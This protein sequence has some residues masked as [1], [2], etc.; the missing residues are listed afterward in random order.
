MQG[1]RDAATQRVKRAASPA[2]GNDERGREGATH[3]ADVAKSANA[4]VTMQ[5]LGEGHISSVADVRWRAGMREAVRTSVEAQAMTGQEYAQ[6]ALAERR[7][8]LRALFEMGLFD[9]ETRAMLEEVFTRF[10][11]EDADAASDEEER[12]DAQQLYREFQETF[13]QFHDS[14]KRI[15]RLVEEA[16]SEEPW[17]TIEDNDREAPAEAAGSAAAPSEDT[18]AERA[19]ETQ[20]EL[21]ER[22]TAATRSEEAGEAPSDG[23]AEEADAAR[24]AIEP[25]AADDAG[26]TYARLASAYEAHYD[27]L[28]SDEQPLFSTEG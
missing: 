21:I 25:E 16:E 24:G 28:A 12:V 14:L 17:P 11:R 15:F 7:D 5:L 4:D 3:R 19:S 8:P 27:E 6:D 18:A 1:G 26:D 9:E 10:N 13:E 23:E 2:A 20:E 22:V